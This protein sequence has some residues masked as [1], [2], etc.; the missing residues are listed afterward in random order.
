LAGQGVKSGKKRGRELAL[1]ANAFSVFHS[2]CFLFS[3]IKPV[4]CAVTAT[5]MIAAHSINSLRTTKLFA[6][7]FTACD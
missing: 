1:S 7:V 5:T 3:G 4:A 2:F 6:V